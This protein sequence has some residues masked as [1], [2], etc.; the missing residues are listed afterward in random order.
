MKNTKH[1]NPNIFFPVIP[2]F[3]ER[4]FQPIRIHAA[5]HGVMASE[6]LITQHTVGQ[7]QHVHVS[8]IVVQGVLV[9]HK[10]LDDGVCP[11][12]NS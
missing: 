11:V 2:P 5:R 4:S 12:E 6:L 3:L 9:P 7:C 8:Q 10:N 1:R